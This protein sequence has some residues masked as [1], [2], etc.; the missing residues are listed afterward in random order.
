MAYM[1]SLG[2]C[3][4]GEIISLGDRKSALTKLTELVQIDTIIHRT[5]RLRK[6]SL[7]FTANRKDEKNYGTVFANFIEEHELGD[8]IRLPR[9]RNPNTG[10]PI[11][12]FI[13]IING[14]AL[15]KFCSTKNLFP[16]EE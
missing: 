4:L 3:G 10:N 1:N 2:C 8:V 13:W 7:I 16:K 5:G 14:P 15:F 9:F 11:S 6:G 12:T